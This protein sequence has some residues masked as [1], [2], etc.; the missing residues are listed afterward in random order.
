MATAEHILGALQKAVQLPAEGGQQVL[1]MF[2]RLAAGKAMGAGRHD[3]PSLRRNLKAPDNF[4][5][6]K[7]FSIDVESSAS[8]RTFL[9][10]NTYCILQRCSRT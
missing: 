7:E 1:H 4:A 6:W 2:G 9:R 10:P 8:V 3:I 5:D